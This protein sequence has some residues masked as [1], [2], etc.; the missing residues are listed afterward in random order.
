LQ[1]K[2]SELPR[3]LKQAEFN[4]ARELQDRL[5][6]EEVVTIGNKTYYRQPELI[7]NR[8]VVSDRVEQCRN[9][10]LS[11]TNCSAG[12]KDYSKAVRFAVIGDAPTIEES[13]KDGPFSGF[14][15][16]GL[17]NQF[18]ELR[19][20]DQAVFINA[21]SCVP[22]DGSVKRPPLPMELKACR[23]N[24]MDQLEAANVEYAL[25]CGAQAL[26][27]WRNDVRLED[28]IGRWGVWKNQWMV[29]PI[30]SSSHVLH[31]RTDAT[32]VGTWK[33]DIRKFV[34]GVEEGRKLDALEISCTRFK[35]RSGIKYYDLDGLGWC[36][37]HF[38]KGWDG[39]Q[40]SRLYWSKE[41]DGQ[42]E[43]NLEE[44][45]EDRK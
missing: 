37:N 45:K 18:R 44:T 15:N 29:L 36:E 26:K 24:L 5:G 2:V 13:K 12:Y 23:K 30:W 3:G 35:C 39:M 8:I 6:S 11:G 7:R 42:L 22:Q 14:Q 19:V 10:K 32:I 43:M 1:E 27:V 28:V 34:S 38:E 16:R 40:K 41:S 9:C 20:L 31:N 25:I 17:I 21:I 4:F 33:D